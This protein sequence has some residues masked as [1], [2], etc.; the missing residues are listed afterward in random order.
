MLALLQELRRQHISI[1]IEDGG[2]ALSY[3]GDAPKEELVKSL[4]SQSAEIL[5]FFNSKKIF[6][7]E[8]FL[9][10]TD[11][12]DFP[13]S[14]SQ[15]RLLFIQRFDKGANAYHIPYLVQLNHDARLQTLEQAFKLVAERHSI[16][17]TIYKTDDNGVSYQQV[18]DLPISIE[19]ITLA[20]IKAFPA[21]VQREI[22][23]P[24]D[25]STELPMRLRHY[26]IGGDDYILMLWHHI[27]FDGWSLEI[28]MNELASAYSSLCAGKEVS[29]PEIGISY[30]DYAVWQRS[31]LSGEVLDTLL[32]Y[33]KST[34]SGYETLALL[35]D[36]TRP[37]RIDYEGEDH[38][39]SLDSD[40]S[41]GLHNIAK[42]QETTLY[43]VLLS[44]F[45]ITL[46][47]LTGQSDIVV[48]T[49]SENRN[50]LQTQALMG[51]FVN[52]LALRAIVDPDIRI[53]ALIRRVHQTVTLAK[54][55]QDLPFEQLVHAL[56]VERESSRHPVFQV[57][58]GLQSF[59]ND[60][61]HTANLPFTHVPLDSS[62][63][64]YSP[65]QFDLGL[66][67]EDGREQ[68][69]GRFNYAVSL[70]NGETVGRFSDIYQ[71]ILRAIVAN[72]QQRLSDIDLVPQRERQTLLIARNQTDAEFPQNM[73]LSD[74]FERQAHETPDNVALLFEN[75]KLTY[76]EL[77]ARA[78][79]LARRIH[80]NYVK[81]GRL[82][83][84]DTLIALYLD[85]SI[86]MVVG[87]LAI[88]KVGG[89]YVPI[90][91]EH[92]DGRALFILHDT[93]T[94]I[95]IT[96]DRY[97]ERLKS[98]TS[99]MA[100][101]PVLLS[102]SSLDHGMDAVASVSNYVSKPSDL[103]Y[104]LYTSGTT[105]KPKGV[106]VGHHSIVNL[107]MH[108][109]RAFDFSPNEVV[110]WVAAYIFDASVE[111]LFLPLLTGARLVIP[112]QS[113]I[114]SVEYM[115]R[116]ITSRKVTHI[117]ATT[118]YLL[119]LGYISS[120]YIKRVFTA[121]EACTQA[122]K[123]QWGKLLINLYGPT[124][125]AVDSSQCISFFEHEKVNCIGTPLSNIKF[126]VLSDN[127]QV[128]PVGCPGELYI[129]G[130][131]LARGYL[132]QPE[133][134]ADKFIP[135]PFATEVD[136]RRGFTRLYRSGDI[137]RWL[138]D[139]NLEYLGRNDGQ[140]K[141]RGYR[142]ETGEIE[143]ALSEIPNV[144]RAVVIDRERG[145]QKYLAAY[146]VSIPGC[147]L[148][149]DSIRSNLASRLPEYMIPLTFTSIESV[150]MTI[151]GKLDRN[152]LP[153]PMIIDEDKY[154][155][156][157]DSLE[158]QLAEIWQELLD[159]ERVGIR[160]NFFRIGGNSI[161]CVQM[162]YQAGKRGIVFFTQDAYENN[163][164]ERLA[165]IVR[166]RAAIA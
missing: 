138:P 24:F 60:A 137:V 12:K 28:F 79:E 13:L 160:D 99:T 57:M 66:F 135:N 36:K 88:L 18:L 8:D 87:I 62:G 35:T 56:D 71:G 91:P 89:A 98:L 16:L 154:C 37:N 2:L 21:Q 108:Q 163:T 122:L 147:V 70:F 34:L 76:K 72:P 9:R 1:W 145:G 124:E 144:Q 129:G 26:S 65:A 134:T 148:D 80:Y 104:V 128:V 90:S 101:P 64:S 111:Q 155:A 15:E 50:H 146:I 159:L 92:P 43:V 39:F 161:L 33:W 58:F 149:F 86:E 132:N 27:A 109:A 7:E 40:L 117:I 139:G 110:L 164:I 54:A 25:L 114:R 119:S 46:K 100:D 51:L 53:E 61:I 32:N 133:L 49:P 59:V 30:A 55:H 118:S 166:N 94:F 78:N 67:L 20:D 107:I 17:R 29:L 82:I 102:E 73:T 81:Q 96:Q 125:C 5:D 48:G 127:L 10:L 97:I 153:E 131:C 121:G 52:S 19:T 158:R 106:M 143:S 130:V 11:I 126:Y 47:V 156:P 85:R 74:L 152:A 93:K 84:P 113:K 142:I 68:I 103:A 120:P 41:K 150:P 22:A 6:S 157:R 136:K 123:E 42:N 75:E 95:L 116:L 31:Y 63:I 45:Y 162:V 44:G 105:G 140:I 4:K 112:A 14:F 83:K 115:K 165:E 141:I 69:H 23:R 77:N 38:R 151:N 3:H